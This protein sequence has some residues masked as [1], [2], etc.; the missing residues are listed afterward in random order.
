MSDVAAMVIQ[1][2]FWTAIFSYV[3]YCFGRLKE[4]TAKDDQ[5][6]FLLEELADLT[7]TLL[8]LDRDR[9]GHIRQELA[10]H[11]GA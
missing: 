8:P 9:I 5:I 6:N 2:G 4:R 11:R 3:F 10:K 7:E 1:T